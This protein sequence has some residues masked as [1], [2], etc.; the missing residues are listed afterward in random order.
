MK[1]L[2]MGYA[3]L[4]AKRL[5]LLAILMGMEI[6]LGRLTFG[7]SFLKFGVTF[8]VVVLIAKWYGPLWGGTMAIF[9]DY[10]GVLFSGQPYYF[11]F[12]LSAIAGV[13]IYGWFFYNHE[14]LGWLRVIIATFLVLLLVNALMNTIWIAQMSNLGVA[15][16][17]KM[18]EIRAIKQL[19]MLPIQSILIYLVVNNKQLETMKEKVFA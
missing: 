5:A 3:K 6:A 11:G 16:T 18:F 1:T 13:V 2:S 15:A 14:H 19:A 17:E 7:P 12:T 4:S 8:I 9:T 10:I